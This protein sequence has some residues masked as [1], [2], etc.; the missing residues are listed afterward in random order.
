MMQRK[1][2]LRLSAP[3]KRCTNV[4]AP[5]RGASAPARRAR[6]RWW[7]KIM[8]SAMSEPEHPR[9]ISAFQ[10]DAR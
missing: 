6:R 8:R 5:V 4:I 2:T 3:P 7:A 10:I 1:C 9:L